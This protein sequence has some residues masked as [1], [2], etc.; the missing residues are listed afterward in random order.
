MLPMLLVHKKEMATT[1]KKKNNNP[2]IY[3]I[4]HTQL[5]NISAFNVCVLISVI[6]KKKK[7][8]V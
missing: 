5:Y 3:K 6:L 8:V 2:F 7:N 4:T 1:K